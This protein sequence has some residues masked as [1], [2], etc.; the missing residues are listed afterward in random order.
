M[1]VLSKQ[2]T[3][4]YTDSKLFRFRHSSAIWA[5]VINIILNF[6]YLIIIFFPNVE[7]LKNIP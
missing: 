2:L 3:M 5:V 4:V 7:L 1:G 6:D